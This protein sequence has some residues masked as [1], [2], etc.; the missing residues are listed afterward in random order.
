MGLFRPEETV[1]YLGAKNP[2]T[3]ISLI[4]NSSIINCDNKKNSTTKSTTLK[5]SY[6]NN[7]KVS[8]DKEKRKL[9][10]SQPQGDL[11]HTCHVGI[12]G[13]TFGILNV[14]KF[15]NK[16]FYFLQKNIFLLIF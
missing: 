15:I 14:I 8:D 4:T 1:A 5:H 3:S 16:F 11:R 10:I 6:T 7:N 9:L 13:K 12:D 2:S